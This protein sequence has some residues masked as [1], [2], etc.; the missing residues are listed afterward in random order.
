MET[1]FGELQKEARRMDL[2]LPALA[3]IT[4]FMQARAEPN[5]AAAA[6]D[7]VSAM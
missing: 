1:R 6:N 5:A 4:T 7:A 3:R 2:L